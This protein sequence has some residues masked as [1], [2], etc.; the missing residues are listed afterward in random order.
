[1][2]FLPS[3]S[4]PLLSHR[5]KPASHGGIDTTQWCLSYIP[6]LASAWIWALLPP[7]VA[8]IP[9]EKKVASVDS[10]GTRN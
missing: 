10:V 8:C 3:S 5:S 7:Q 2:C 9:F 6:A 4:A 1:M